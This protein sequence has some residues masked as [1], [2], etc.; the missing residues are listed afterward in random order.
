MRAHLL[1]S[2]EDAERQLVELFASGHCLIIRACWPLRPPRL[3][4]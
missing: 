1:A 4:Y 2:G 3:R